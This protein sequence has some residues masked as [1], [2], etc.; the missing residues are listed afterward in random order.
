MRKFLGSP[1]FGWVSATIMLVSVP[2]T[3]DS[4]FAWVGWLEGKES[5][6]VWLGSVLTTAYVVSVGHRGWEP[7]K[8][9]VRRKHRTE[10]PSADVVD[11]IEACAIIDGYIAP[12]TRDM[13]SG[14]KITVRQDFIERFDKV[15]GAKLGEYQYNGPLLHQWMQ[16]NAARFLIKLR[17]EMV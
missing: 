12:A 2:S 15:T 3:I 10:I 7:F 16:S 9:W 1:W 13:R 17:G 5:I 6:V 11:Y 14:V 4:A 8:S